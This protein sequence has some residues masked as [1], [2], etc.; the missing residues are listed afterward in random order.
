MDND[1]EQFLDD[2]ILRK[3]VEPVLPDRQETLAH[4]LSVFERAGTEL[5]RLM[6]EE[7]QRIISD[8]ETRMAEYEATVRDTIVEMKASHEHTLQAHDRMVKRFETL[9]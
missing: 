1:T 4:K 2:D 5:R 8:F 9:G 7:R 6:R 3:Q